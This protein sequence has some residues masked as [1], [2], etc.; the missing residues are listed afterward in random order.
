M[1][2]APWNLPV[3]EWKQELV[4]P[5]PPDQVPLLTR[6]LVQMDI[7]LQSIRSVNS[8]EAYFLSL[9]SGNQHVATFTN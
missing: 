4:V 9:T 1:T 3:E 2:R 5:L 6:Y 8:L 7:D